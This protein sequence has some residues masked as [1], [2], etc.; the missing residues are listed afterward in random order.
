MGSKRTPEGVESEVEEIIDEFNWK[1][2]TGG[3]CF[4]EARFRSKYFISLAL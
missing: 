2:F 1:T 4:Y 3:N